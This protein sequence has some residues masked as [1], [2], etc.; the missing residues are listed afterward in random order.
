MANMKKVVEIKSDI[1]TQIETLRADVAEL[2]KTIKLQAQTTAK[3]K[4]DELT[5][6]ANVKTAEARQ[7]YTELASTAETTIRE[8]PLTAIAVAAGIG[9]LFG[10]ISRR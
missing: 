6:L 8:Q 1:P 10:M 9:V 3:I 2:T 7:K 4:K 5:D